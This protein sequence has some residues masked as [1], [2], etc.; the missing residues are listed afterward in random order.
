MVG[1]VFF[2]TFA[3]MNIQDLLKIYA[4]SPQVK[5]LADVVGKK[6]VKTIFLEGLMCS[7]APMV[8]GSLASRTKLTTTV[9]ILQDSEEAGYF[10]HD[11]VQLLDDKQVLFFPSSYRRAIKYAQRDA[12]NE[13]LRTEVLSKLSAITLPLLI[14]T[15]PEAIAELV[16]SK[17]QLDDQT[18][19][20]H[21]GDVLDVD[22]TLESLRSLGFHE[23]D[24]VYEPG[25]FAL[26]GSILDVYSYSSEFPFRI[27]LFGDD[28]DSIRTFEVETQLSKDK[29]EQVEIVPEIGLMETEKIPFLS[30]L[31]ESTMLVAKD[32]LYVRD[33]I[34]RTYQ[35]G[36]SQQALTERLEAAT[37]M[38][39][40]AIRMEMKK[41]IQLISGQTFTRDM[42]GFRRIEI[43]HRPTGMPNATIAFHISPQPQFHKNFELLQQSLE[44]YLADGYR[45]C[46]LADSKKQLDRLKDIFAEKGTVLFDSV[47]KTLHEGYST[48]SINII[49][50][51]TKHAVVRW[52]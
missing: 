47:E 36:F 17:K 22:A 9:F 2:R 46:I 37:E 45:L 21:Q 44:Q 29:C 1:S 32:F 10:Y 3:V 31:P 25:Q 5:A 23:V 51:Q 38:E 27:D 8:F 24:Y 33:A 14:V 43:G 6:S 49:C 39:E 41:E 4:Q 13:I 18:L 42:T 15:Y 52:P 20:M 35:E 26:R 16:I 48:V 34:D 11:L 7:S 50:A 40:Q 12:A 19:V 30:F 28:I